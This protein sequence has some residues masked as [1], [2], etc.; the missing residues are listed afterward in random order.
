M[1]KNAISDEL[2]LKPLLGACPQT[3]WHKLPLAAEVAA[4]SYISDVLSL[5][6][7]ASQII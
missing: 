2:K 4:I 6:V 3:P 7:W 5:M 1:T